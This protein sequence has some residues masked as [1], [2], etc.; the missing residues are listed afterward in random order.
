MAPDLCRG[1]GCAYLD[2][3]RLNYYIDLRP[4]VKQNFHLAPLS[5]G[6]GAGAGENG[7]V[8]SPWVRYNVVTGPRLPQ[9]P[10]GDLSRTEEVQS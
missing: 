6:A 10:L 8:I 1:Q 5:P 9:L 3:D 4:K 7:I 2:K